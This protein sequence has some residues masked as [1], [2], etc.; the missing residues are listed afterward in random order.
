MTESVV[1]HPGR[2]GGGRR[3]RTMIAL[4]REFASVR[5]AAVGTCGALLQRLLGGDCRCSDELVRWKFH[6][7]GS[8]ASHDA[9]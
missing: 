1:G 6:A 4:V 7:S 3:A 9:R 8:S 5:R 2:E